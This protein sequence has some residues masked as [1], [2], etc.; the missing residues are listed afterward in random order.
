MTKCIQNIVNIS[1]SCSRR[2]VVSWLLRLVASFSHMF[3]L[4]LLSPYNEN[5]HLSKS[6]IIL[7]TTKWFTYTKESKRLW[8]SDKCSLLRS[9][10]H[11][12]A[13]TLIHRKS[14]TNMLY[15]CSTIMKV[16]WETDLHVFSQY[17]FYH[18]KF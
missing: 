6:L 16:V 12:Y 1:V 15:L 13:T 11:A 14:A 8:N 7:M 18:I 3:L 10:R 9:L 5:P 17:R 2:L 4:L